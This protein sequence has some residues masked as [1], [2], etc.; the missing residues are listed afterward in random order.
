MEE[1]EVIN[2]DNYKITTKHKKCL[3]KDHI[4]KRLVKK[5]KNIKKE[6]I[7]IETETQPNLGDFIDVISI[8]VDNMNNIQDICTSAMVCRSFYYALKDNIKLWKKW[9]CILGLN[10]SNYLEVDNPK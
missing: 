8:I 10:F 7:V 1:E 2:S 9:C 4:S 6:T 3:S 5:Q